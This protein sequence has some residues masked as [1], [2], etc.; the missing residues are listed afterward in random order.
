MSCRFHSYRQWN[1]WNIRCRICHIGKP[2]ETVKK[3]ICKDCWDSYTRLN[4]HALDNNEPWISPY[5]MGALN[6]MHQ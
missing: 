5:E 1:T 3:G 4:K 6:M 2:K